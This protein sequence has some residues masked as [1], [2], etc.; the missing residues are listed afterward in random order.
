MP[1]EGD[2]LQL[3]QTL[4]ERLDGDVSL[5]TLAA[6]A[7]WSPFH[8]HRAFRRVVGETPK[9]YTQ[10]LRLE[11]AAARLATGAEPVL[12]VAAGAGFASHEVFTRA[13]RRQF[14]ETPSEYRARAVTG[15]ASG[16]R[17]RHVALTD[18]TG[19]CVGLYHMH[20]EPLLRR[21]PMPMLSIER[22]ELTP[23]HVLIARARC[24]R[25]ELSKAI[26]ECLGKTFP[27]AM[28]TGV[29]LAGRPFTR[30][31]STGPG[32]FTIEAGCVLAAAAPGTNDVEAG[33]LPG[34]PSAVAMHGGSY[35]TL[36][37]TYAEMERWI[38]KNGWRPAGPPWES[39]IT[40]PAE[41]PDPAN[42]RTE[43]FWPLGER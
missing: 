14:G 19:P 12:S 11:R 32:L 42:W 39:Y 31:L 17:A 43:I 20:P 38:E 22:R 13:F 30:Y 33:L 21:L 40:D 34:G 1:S 27:Y 25:H 37:E 9:Q 7:G 16:S 23:A 29:P 3:L 8:F 5:E 2:I 15:M 26:G 24:A 18:A 41:H 28:G 35:D 10:R 36:S 6:R 4:R